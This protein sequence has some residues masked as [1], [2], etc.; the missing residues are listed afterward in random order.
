MVHRM[1]SD[2]D[3]AGDLLAHDQLELVLT[4]SAIFVAQPPIERDADEVR[5]G[6]VQL[7]L[8]GLLP[9]KIL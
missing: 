1:Q 4:K 9:T 2:V 8:K 6:H 5:V 3:G 7:G